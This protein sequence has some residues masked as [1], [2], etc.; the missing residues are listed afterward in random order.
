VQ[1]IY[2]YVPETNHVPTVH[3][4]AAA[5][6]L[7]FPV[8][9]CNVTSHVKHVLYFYYI[10]TSRSKCAV[11]NMAAFCSSLITCFTGLLLGY[12]L[13]DFEL[14]PAAPTINP[15]TFTC[16][17]PRAVYPLYGLYNLESSQLLS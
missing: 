11:L 17:V 13:G 8:S 5:L 10:S 14:V 7:Q 15:N 6:Y 9:T 4:V 1:C 3:T 12:C 16:T 2:N